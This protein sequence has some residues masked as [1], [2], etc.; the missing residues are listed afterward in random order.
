[1]NDWLAKDWRAMAALV[2]SGFGAVA[3]TVLLYLVA[4]M[5]L[6]EHGWSKATE[7]PRTDTIRWIA[8]IGAI[9]LVLVLYSLGYGV[10]RRALRGRW[11]DKSLDLEGGD[12]DHEETAP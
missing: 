5:M 3:L 9:G 2:L 1:M 11:G 8:L 6:P 10:G 4:D 7:G 12:D